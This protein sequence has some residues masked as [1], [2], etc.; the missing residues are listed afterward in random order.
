MRRMS[1]AQFT[2]SVVVPVPPLVPRKLT[3]MQRV[4]QPLC[5][6]AHAPEP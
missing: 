6:S 1:A 5:Q 4:Q 3:I 2:A